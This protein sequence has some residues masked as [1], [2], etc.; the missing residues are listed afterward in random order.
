VNFT[1]LFHSH[2][3]DTMGIEWVQNQISL[4]IG[5]MEFKVGIN[6]QNFDNTTHINK[7]FLENSQN[8][9]Q[10]VGGQPAML[11]A[12]GFKEWWQTVESDFAVLYPA[13]EITPLYEFVQNPV[14]AANLKKAIIAY[15][16]GQLGFS[17]DFKPLPLPL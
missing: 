4:S 17:G 7:K 2:L 9:T 8:V 6:W 5:W 15:G 14:I 16:T 13:S 3:I 11:A 10:I 12:G 1:A